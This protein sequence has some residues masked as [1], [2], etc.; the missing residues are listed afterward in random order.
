MDSTKLTRFI[1]LL[2]SVWLFIFLCFILPWWAFFLPAAFIGL[3][4]PS[5][6]QSL[7]TGF[8]ASYVVWFAVAL[9]RD[10]QAAGRISSHIAVLF[11]LPHPIFAVIL[12]GAL[13]G[14][15]SGPAALTSYLGLRVWRDWRHRQASSGGL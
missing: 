14:I 15:L 3:F 2:T 13:A 5:A 6:L 4:M 9:I 12:S 1:L 10:T 8:L 7:F 11:H